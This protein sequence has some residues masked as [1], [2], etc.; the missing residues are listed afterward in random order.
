MKK[1]IFSIWVENQAGVLSNV[2]SLFGKTG[3]NI[4]SLAVG[5]TENSFVSRIT[6]VTEGSEDLLTT[7]I[8]KMNEITNLI[9]VKKITDDSS[10]LRELALIMVEAPLEK[11][12][13]IITIAEIFRAEVVD[14]GMRTMTL[15]ISGGK[16]KIQAIED[17]LKPFGIREIVRTGLIAIDRGH[18]F[19]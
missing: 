4:D 18:R 11:R 2:A 8:S 1:Q 16:D 5:T 6:I 9:K 14:V 17:L 19:E 15:E 7:V 13:D 3:L 12:Q 10:V